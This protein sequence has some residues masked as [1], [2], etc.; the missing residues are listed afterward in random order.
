MRAKRPKGSDQGWFWSK[1]WQRGEAVAERDIL[2]GRLSRPFR[3]VDELKKHLSAT[4][5]NVAARDRP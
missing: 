3:S 4:S 5:P 2:A 1:E